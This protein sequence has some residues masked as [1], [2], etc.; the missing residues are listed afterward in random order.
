MNAG[1]RAILSREI[2]EEQLTALIQW[3]ESDEDQR[4]DEVVA[5]LRNIHHGIKRPSL[6]ERRYHTV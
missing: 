3:I 2:F 5:T 4:H 1:G 6:Q